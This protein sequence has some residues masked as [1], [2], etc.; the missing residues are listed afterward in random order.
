MLET[1]RGNPHVIDGNGGSLGTELVLD[2]GEILGGATSRQ[3]QLN[4]RLL[5]EVVQLASVQQGVRQ[6]VGQ[7]VRDDY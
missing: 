2:Q 7:G 1:V 6:G 4:A 3:G 5:Q